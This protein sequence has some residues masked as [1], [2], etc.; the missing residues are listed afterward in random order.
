MGTLISPPL[1][2]RK[3]TGKVRKRSSAVPPGRRQPHSKDA[4]TCTSPNLASPWEPPRIRWLAAPHGCSRHSRGSGATAELFTPCPRQFSPLPGPFS[5]HSPRQS[6]S[7]L[8]LALSSD[9]HPFSKA[10]QLCL[11]HDLKASLH[12]G[13]QQPSCSHLDL[14]PE[15]AS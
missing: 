15:R 5:H 13:C 8:A 2:F 14:V 6:W 7:P 12:P 9:I 3:G 1:S 4:P 10:Y 11:E